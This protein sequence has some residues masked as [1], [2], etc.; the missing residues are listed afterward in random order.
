MAEITKAFENARSPEGIEALLNQPWFGLPKTYLSNRQNDC[1]RLRYVEGFTKPA[2]AKELGLKIHHVQYG[3]D[4]GIRDIEY[5]EKYPEAARSRKRDLN[6]PE[7]NMSA[8]EMLKALRYWGSK[9]RARR[10]FG[11]T[12]K[13][14]D[15]L[16]KKHNI[17]FGYYVD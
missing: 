16:Y 10:S 11:L 3:L 7:P 17:N 15:K 9:H 8:E 6:E 13:Q 4:S 12:P 2:I 1:L 5:F 14:F